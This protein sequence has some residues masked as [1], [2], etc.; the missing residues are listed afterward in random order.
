MAKRISDVF[1]INQ[2][3]P[4]IHFNFRQPKRLREVDLMVTPR[5][6]N[7]N[8]NASIVIL[9]NGVFLTPPID[10]NLTPARFSLGIYCFTQF[11]NDVLNSIEI[12]FM[13]NVHT[14]TDWDIMVLDNAAIPAPFYTTQFNFGQN[15]RIAISFDEIPIKGLWLDLSAPNLKEA[16]LAYQCVFHTPQININFTG[17]KPIS[18]TR[19]NATFFP[20]SYFRG[21]HWTVDE[22]QFFSDKY[23][24]GLT[25]IKLY[26]FY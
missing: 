9:S 4:N 8:S 22:V 5:R 21:L 23:V 19:Q 17:Y 7:Y 24:Q 20:V 2:L 15:T 10:L 26:E 16:A 11:S 1:N 14:V 18:L 13:E 6:Y 3:H 12:L 25:I